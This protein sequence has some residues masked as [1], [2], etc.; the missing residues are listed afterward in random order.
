[1]RALIKFFKDFSKCV[2]LASE[3]ECNSE[4]CEYVFNEMIHD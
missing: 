3:Y 4:Y 2:R 1:M